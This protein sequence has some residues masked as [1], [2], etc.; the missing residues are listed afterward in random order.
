MDGLEVTICDLQDFVFQLTKEVVAI[1]KSQ[2]VISSSAACGG[3]RRATPFLHSP[4][5]MSAGEPAD[6]G[7]PVRGHSVASGIFTTSRPSRV[8]RARNVFS[9]MP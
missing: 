7:G 1:L 2:N 3:A 8:I 5:G 4:F 6:G 9:A